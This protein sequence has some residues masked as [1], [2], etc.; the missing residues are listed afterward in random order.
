M[1]DKFK[2]INEILENNGI[3]TGLFDNIRIIDAEKGMVLECQ[4]NGTLA[5]TGFCYIHDTSSSERCRNCTSIRAY[6]SNETGVKLEYVGN[7]V[8]LVFSTPIQIYGRKVVVELIKDITKSM[9]SEAF[10]FK[11]SDEVTSVI[12]NLNVMATTDSLTQLYN[13]RYIDEKLPNY[14]ADARRLRRPMIVAKLDLDNFRKVNDKYGYQAGDMILKSVSKIISSF[15]RRGSDWAARYGGEEF[16]LC[17]SGTAKEDAKKILGRIRKKIAES[18]I[19]FENQKI[20]VTISI[21]FSELMAGDTK[22]TL[23]DRCD[24]L[25]FKAKRNGKNRLEC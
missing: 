22:D 19:E 24:K 4:D 6:N 5:E 17:F 16:F 13:R 18:N 20:R 2:D 11:R 7:T 21:G 15:S 14:I 12:N 10:D 8:F 25:L 3:F 1:D 23:I 9:S